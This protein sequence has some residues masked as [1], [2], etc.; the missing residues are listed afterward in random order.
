[1]DNST[2]R[3]N[4]RKTVGSVGRS[5]KVRRGLFAVGVVVGGGGVV[6]VAAAPVAGGGDAGEE[7]GCPLGELGIVEMCLVDVDGVVG[8]LL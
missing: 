1:M 7:G 6:V 5:S 8:M 4:A 3:S 2:S